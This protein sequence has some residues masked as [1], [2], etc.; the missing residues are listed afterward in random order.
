MQASSFYVY[1]TEY[2]GW[3]WRSEM[4]VFVEAVKSRREGEARKAISGAERGS[5]GRPVQDGIRGK[6]LK[7]KKKKKKKKKGGGE[8]SLIRAIFLAHNY[9]SGQSAN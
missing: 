5:P 1:M 3:R 2:G 7:A 6:R 8:G 4:A 9:V